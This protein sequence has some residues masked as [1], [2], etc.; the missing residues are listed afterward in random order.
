MLIIEPQ[1]NLKGKVYSLINR[2]WVSLF[3]ISWIINWGEIN[4]SY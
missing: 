1:S 4:E 3:L 2:V